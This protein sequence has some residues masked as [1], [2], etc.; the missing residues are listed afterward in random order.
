MKHCNNCGFDN[1]VEDIFCKNCGNRFDVQANVNAAPVNNVQYDNQNLS[2]IQ[3]N[4]NINNVNQTKHITTD[5][6]VDIYIGPNVDK[7]KTNGFS[8]CTFFFGIMYVFYRKMWLLGIIWMAL[9]VVTSMFLSS[10]QL[11]I[12]IIFSLVMA[13]KFKG[14]YINHV[15]EEVYKIKDLNTKKTDEE[16]AMI[17]QSKGGTSVGL[18]ILSII[19]YFGFLIAM[20][21]PAMISS[22]KEQING[23]FNMSG[24]SIEFNESSGT[25]GKLYMDIPEMFEESYYSTSDYKTY[26]L[27]KTDNCSCYLNLMKSRSSLYAEDAKKYMEKLSNYSNHNSFG[28]IIK[29]DINSNTWYY[30]SFMTNYNKKYFYSI[31]K[32][33]FLY[34]IEFG[35][36]KDTDESCSNAY[37]NII[38][39][40]RFD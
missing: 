30:T 34:Y 35:I 10:F 7:L 17:C 37:K 9:A 21:L 22:I 19:I 20:V 6:L 11:V 39:S 27:K 23:F 13:I 2:Q 25:I 33:N 24:I 40:M 29:K 26:R 15:R 38:D 16:I 28:E 8:F 3:N 4:V 14:M 18:V 5:E 1:N 12:N 32:D 36:S 31:L